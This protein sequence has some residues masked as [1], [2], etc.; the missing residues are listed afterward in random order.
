MVSI[1][2]ADIWVCQ[3]T[4]KR[5]DQ[6]PYMIKSL[7][8]GENLPPIQLGRMED[9]SIQV[10]DGHHRLMAYWL[11]SRK[12]LDKTEYLI[13]ESEW[14]RPRFGQMGDQWIFDKS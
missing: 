2:I 1:L 10:E 13:V 14:V 12:I 6:I 5:A 3:R 11:S 7:E 8:D 9:G 4:L